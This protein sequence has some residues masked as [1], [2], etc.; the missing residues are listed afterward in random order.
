MDS[1]NGSLLPDIE[2]LT[3]QLARAVELLKTS[4]QPGS[5]TMYV[6][7]WLKDTRIFLNSLSCVRKPKTKVKLCKLL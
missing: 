3:E 1:E 2:Q 7:T 5:H 6:L 4:P